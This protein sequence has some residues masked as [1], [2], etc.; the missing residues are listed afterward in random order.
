MR[1]RAV[2]VA[3]HRLRVERRRD[4]EVLGDAVE[5]PARHPQLV[6]DLERAQRA[7]LELPLAGHDLGVDAGER[8]PGL[9]ARVEVGLDD[10]AAEDLVGADAAVVGALRC[11]EAAPRGSRA[12][13]PALKNVYSCSMPNSGSWSANFSATGA[14]AARVLV[15]CGVMSVSSTSLITSTSSPPRIGSGHDE[16]GL[17]HAVGCLARRLV[18][19]RTVEAPDRQARE[20]PC[21]RGSWSSTADAR[22]ARCRRSRCTQP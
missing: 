10:V 4:A 11:R 3:V 9:E 13:A 1:A 17:E 16:H 6:G 22:S 8:E 12:G 14:S 19:A 20:S 21:R 7:D 18:G 15:G 2:P 5:Q